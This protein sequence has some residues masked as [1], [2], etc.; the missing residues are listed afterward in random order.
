M[1]NPQTGRT[2]RADRTGAR[3]TLQVDIIADFVCPWCYIGK[4]RL[5]EALLAVHGPSIVT[6]Y[7]YQLN[8]AI[9]EEGVGFEEYLAS[10][11]G[12]P[13]KLQ[14]LL[15]E[16]ATTGKAGGIQFNFD[17][18]RRIPNT[19]NAHRLMRLA[20]GEGVGVSNLAESIFRAFFEEGAD[21]SQ[22]EVLVGLG[23]RC[24]LPQ[25]SIDRALDDDA[26]RRAVLAQEAQIRRGGVTRVP[27]FLVNKRLFVPGAQNTENLVNVFDRAMFGEESDQP[28]SPVVH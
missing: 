18:I 9:A 27:D 10:H 4:R 23:A 7:P 22:R 28:V 25:Q 14:P 3:A 21:I 13:E 8:P 2:S 24:G 26:S 16:L 19:L 1:I 17:R 5:D 20:D 12:D 15:A 6:W 11:F